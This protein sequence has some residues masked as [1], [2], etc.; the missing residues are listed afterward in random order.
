MALVTGA[1]RG[2]G[3]RGGDEEDLGICGARVGWVTRGDRLG[4][5]R[6]RGSDLGIEAEENRTVQR[7]IAFAQPSIQLL[8]QRNYKRGGEIKQLIKQANNRVAL[9]VIIRSS[10]LVIILLIGLFVE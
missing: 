7:V 9:K 6:S 8:V 4:V 1:V 3:W 2:H 5:Q 10:I